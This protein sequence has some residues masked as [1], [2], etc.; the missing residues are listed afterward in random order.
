MLWCS[1]YKYSC[2][3]RTGTFGYRLEFILIKINLYLFSFYNIFTYCFMNYFRPFIRLLFNSLKLF[4]HLL[5]PS[6]NPRD[7]RVILRKKMELNFLKYQF[8]PAL[9]ISCEWSIHNH[10][11]PR[12]NMQEDKEGGGPSSFSQG[13]SLFLLPLFKSCILHVKLFDV[14]KSAVAS[15]V[16]TSKVPMF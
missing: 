2:N 10:K 16:V 13:L 9:F 11:T 14:Q 12:Q 1:T 6:K 3:S 7:F 8:L 15:N 4:D 5:F